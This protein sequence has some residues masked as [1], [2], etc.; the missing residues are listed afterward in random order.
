MNFFK[1]IT[2]TILGLMLIAGT[3]FAQV[4]QQ[5]GQQGSQL[6]SE[7]VSKEELKNFVATAGEVQSIQRESQ[8]KLQ[9]MVR[10][11]GLEFQRFQMIMMSKQNP[12]MADSV[13]ISDE[14]QASFKKIQPKMSK[15][16]QSMLQRFQSTIKENDMTQ[17]RFQMIAQAMNSSPELQ[18][19]F[20]KMQAA[21]MEEDGDNG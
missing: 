10:T 16:N 21:Q 19:R 2:P 7:D 6:S 12:Q 15:M 18:Q 5:Q 8:A 4:Q 17:Q 13:E 9:E 3:S 11:E 1:K 14:E 20:Q